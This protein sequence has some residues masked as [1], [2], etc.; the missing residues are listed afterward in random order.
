MDYHS[1]RFEDASLMVLKEG[2]IAAIFPANRVDNVVYSHQGLTYG[3]LVLDHSSKLNMVIFIFQEILK[4]YEGLGID[5][6]QLKLLPSIY[7]DKPADELEYLCFKLNAERIRCDILSVVCPKHITLSRDR[8][9]G[10]K[11]GQKHQLAVKET[12][13]F[14]SFWNAILIPNLKKKHN[15]SPVHSLREIE[16]L[17]RRFPTYIRQFNVYDRD[18]IVGGTT[19]FESQRVAHSQYISASDDKN[20]LGTLDILHHYLLT[21]VF[22]DKPFFDFGISNEDQGQHINEGLLYWKEGFSARSIA[23]NFYQIQTKDHILLND[24]ML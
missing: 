21:E 16:L 15:A 13:D 5:S 14:E 11:R 17:H 6:L 3:G 9:N 12:D 19:I 4:Y 23:H 22:N 2:E 18:R 7:H 24:V 20:T 8:I 1:D 10:V